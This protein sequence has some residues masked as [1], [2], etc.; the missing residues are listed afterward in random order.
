MPDRVKIKCS[1]CGATFGER[2]SR[3]RD[4]FQKQCPGCMRLIT[5]DSASGDEN[6]HKAMRAANR[7][8]LALLDQ[9][10]TPAKSSDR[11]L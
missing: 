7:L 9:K 8:R 6:V 10:Q 5:F 1:K 2:A 11:S 3:L 4:G